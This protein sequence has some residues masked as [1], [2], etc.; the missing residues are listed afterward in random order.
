MLNIVFMGTPDFA[1]PTL[2][3]LIASDHTVTA[4]VTQPDRPKG[5]GKRLAAPPVKVVAER[6]N[7]PVLQ[8]RRVKAPEVREQLEAFAPDVMV[9]IA[10]G[11]ILPQ[12]ILDVP[13]FGCINVHASLLPKYRGAAPFQ[14]AIIRGETETGITTMLMDQGMDTGDILL[15]RACA[16]QP[17]DTAQTLHDSLAQRGADLLLETLERLEAGELT[18]IPQRHDEA[19]YAPLLKKT[20][21]RIDWREP[22]E[23]LVNTI[24]G[25]SPWPG[26]YTTFRG[27]TVKLLKA[28]LESR[29]VADFAGTEAAPGTVVALDPRR[30]PVIATGHGFL[31]I[32]EIQPQNKQPMKCS[33]FCR[34][35]H[36]KVGDRLTGN[37]VD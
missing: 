10:Y 25:M 21:G 29:P 18:P 14:W 2:Q 37:A 36:L 19:T 22:A 28:A 8:P 34:G 7:I 15:Q 13:R 32:L 11:Q 16:I 9:V 5:R 31:R 24:R 33:D 12:S 17:D 30:G 4:V 6:Y 35:Y 27:T 3:R 23:T 20:D 26:A 1:I